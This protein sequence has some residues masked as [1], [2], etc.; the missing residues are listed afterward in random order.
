MEFQAQ[1]VP[2]FVSIRAILAELEPLENLY[3]LDN[4]YNV[5]NS[6]RL[7][8]LSW[9]SI[10]ISIKG[11]KHLHLKVHLHRHFQNSYE[12]CIKEVFYYINYMYNIFLYNHE[13]VYLDLEVYETVYL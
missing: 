3:K 10:S 13:T 7:T 5:D 9:P 6:L 11:R 4:L 2:S 1:D 12:F 8:R